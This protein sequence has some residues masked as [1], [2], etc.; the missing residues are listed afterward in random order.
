MDISKEQQIEYKIKLIKTFK[1]FDAF[2]EENRLHYY[3]AGGTAIGAV[4]HKGIIPWD[5]DIDVVMKREDYDKFLSLKQ[6]LDGSQYK[7]IDPSDYG[8]Y[9]PFAKF[10]DDN[11]TIWEVPEHEFILGVFID[12]FPLNH[13]DGDIKRIRRF[14]KKYMRLCSLHFSGYEKLFSKNVLS[15]LKFKHPGTIINWLRKLFICKPLKWYYNRLFWDAEKQ[16]KE[17]TGNYLLNYYTQYPIEKELYKSE[18]FESQIRL[19][20]QDTEIYVMKGY[21]EFLSQLF[22]DYMTPPPLDKQQ[23]HHFHYF[24]DLSKKLTIKQIRND[25][26]KL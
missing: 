25:R 8:Y 16:L 22:G 19:P 10:V 26:N 11:T 7:I 17:S 3:A 14:Q 23:S 20:F 5:D 13:V 12:V 6:K 18:W 15:E 1:A 2:C 21:H 9:L 4:R 24:Y